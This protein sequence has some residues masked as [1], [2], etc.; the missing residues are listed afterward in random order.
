MVALA[1]REMTGMATA[2]FI[3]RPMIDFHVL[4][5]DGVSFDITVPID[6][7]LR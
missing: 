1:T 6:L 4:Q 7:E 3:G 5:T 2:A